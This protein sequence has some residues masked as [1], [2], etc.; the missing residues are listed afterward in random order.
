MPL[1]LSN[2]RAVIENPSEVKTWVFDPTGAFRS[3]GLRSQTT[4]A[5]E[6]LA[7][8]AVKTTAQKILARWRVVCV[9]MMKIPSL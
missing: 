4:V 1:L 3:L 6:V 2:P 8:T 7:M 9:C 5:E